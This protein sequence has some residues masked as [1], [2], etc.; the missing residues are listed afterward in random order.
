LH[1]AKEVTFEGSLQDSS[2]ADV[3]IA[4]HRSLA[5]LIHCWN[6]LIR[7][8]SIFLVP[9][10]ICASHSRTMVVVIR[11]HSVPIGFFVEKY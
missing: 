4:F 6:R 11:S 3:E 7:R 2:S 1:D 9:A 10:M 5:G 8:Y